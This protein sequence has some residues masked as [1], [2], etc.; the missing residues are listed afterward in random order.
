MKIPSMFIQTRV[1]ETLCSVLWESENHNHSRFH[2]AGERIRSTAVM[3]EVAIVTGIGGS[4]RLGVA[5][6]DCCSVRVRKNEGTGQRHCRD[7]KQQ[8]IQRNSVTREEISCMQTLQDRVG[9]G[10]GHAKLPCIHQVLSYTQGY[11]WMQTA[12]SMFVLN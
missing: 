2:P 5:G 1:C 6:V 10:P 3:S 4:W 11:L 7:V 9:G 8:R 12:V